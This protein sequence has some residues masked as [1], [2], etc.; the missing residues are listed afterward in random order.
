[1]AVGTWADVNSFIHR[2]GAGDID[3]DTNALKI[4]LCSSA[5]NIDAT[6]ETYAALIGEL[7]TANGYTNGGEALTTVAWSQTT[8]DEALTA[9]DVVWTASGGAITARF[10]VVYDSTSGYII[11]FLLLDDT[12]ADVSAPDGQTF[13]IDLSNNGVF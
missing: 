3:V 4:A 13:T 2:M 6:V 1:M 8:G 9:D 12:P 11:A 10:A 7:A 5:S